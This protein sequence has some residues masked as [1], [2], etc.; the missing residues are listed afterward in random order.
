[1][2]KWLSSSRL[3]KPSAYSHNSEVLTR[4]FDRGGQFR[5]KGIQRLLEFHAKAPDHTLQ[6]DLFD[7]VDNPGFDLTLYR[8]APLCV[9]EF[10]GHSRVVR[11]NGTDS[12]DEGTAIRDI[13][14][15]SR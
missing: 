6:Q 12:G 11:R 7:R 10:E 8:H 9:L 3:R 1:M 14:N 4:T 2:E 15:T 5:V 13:G